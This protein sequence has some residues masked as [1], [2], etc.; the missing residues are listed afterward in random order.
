LVI[1]V[2]I[3]AMPH[4]LEARHQ[5]LE[6]YRSY[7]SENPHQLSMIDKFEQEYN[8][9]NA[10]QWYT[11]S[12][13]LFRLLN[14]ALRTENIEVLYTFR[15]FIVDL[16]Q[17]L[18]GTH[19][20][21]Y[22]L[23]VYHGGQMSKTEIE[24]YQIGTLVAANGFLSTTRD[25]QVAHHFAG[26][27]SIT[28]RSPS[29]SQEDYIQFVLLQ[30]DIDND[31]SSD[32]IW[33]DIS[34]ISLFPD[35]KEVLFDLGS[36]FEIVNIQYDCE[37]HYW[38]VQMRPSMEIIPRKKAYECYIRQQMK[39]TNVTV[40]FGILL[41]DMG[42]YEQARKYFE[43]QLKDTSTDDDDNR[44]N[45]YYSLGRIYRF[46]DQQEKALKYFHHAEE[47]QR[48]GLPQTNFDLA[49]TLA[50]IGSVYYE[51]N[52]FENELLYYQ[53]S[54]N[55]FQSILPE[56]HIEI[57]RTYCR[58]GFAYSNQRQYAIALEY[59]S[60]SLDIYNKLVSDDHPGM[61]Q[62]LHNMSIIF[63]SLG[64]IEQSLEYCQKALKMREITLPNDHLHVGQSYHQMSVYYKEKHQTD[65]ALQFA[66]RAC[67]IYKEKLSPKHKI[68]QK[69]NDLIE[70]LSI[71]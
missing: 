19:D 65:L 15:Y 70:T 20:N 18:E 69:I 5:M 49:R 64:N 63:Y 50:G 53:Y 13:F 28:G 52:Q 56:N 23:R 35:E 41:T 57:A 31:V 4:T 27:D 60:K 6:E 11:K 25:L 12:C 29:Q 16:C 44:S 42:E 40:L 22:P 38:Y 24:N 46:L 54:M 55:I 14:K 30:I 34:A 48:I 39:E 8:S 3:K 9:N 66:Q 37:H 26:L 21:K 51:L 17:S 33:T 10:I 62:V 43:R 71:L 47:I 61:A 2:L 45:V 58:L 67:S 7:Y 59:L 68:I 1:I 32:I 36:T